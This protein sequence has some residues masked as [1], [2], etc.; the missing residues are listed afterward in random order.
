MLLATEPGSVIGDGDVAALF[1]FVRE[2]EGLMVF[3]VGL[4][5]IDC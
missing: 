1:L 4:P 3:L 2:A 5:V